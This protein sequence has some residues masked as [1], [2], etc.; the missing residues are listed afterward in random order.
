MVII[1]IDLSDDLSNNTA[2]LA[3]CCGDS[4]TGGPILGWEDLS[5][6]LENNVRRGGTNAE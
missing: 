4:M 3:R 1:E 6:Y 5:W 2:K